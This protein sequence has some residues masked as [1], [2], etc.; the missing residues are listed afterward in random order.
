MDI[1]I[2]SPEQYYNLLFV[3]S[4]LLTSVLTSQLRSSC[5]DVRIFEDAGFRK[6]ASSPDSPA[7]FNLILLVDEPNAS[8]VALHM[9]I[10]NL[11]KSYHDTPVAV[12]SAH[13]DPERITRA[14]WAGAKGY[15]HTSLRYEA[16][17]H[18]LRVLMAGGE[19]VY[20]SP[21]P[22]RPNIARQVG[23]GLGGP[24]RRPQV[25]SPRERDVCDLLRQGL[26]NRS[27]RRRLC[28]LRIQSRFTFAIS[29][30]S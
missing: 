14:V 6:A 12:I 22:A 17:I 13:D 15:I 8:S 24:E 10:E 27:S 3:G 11:R 30:E 23:V 21:I 4:G 26:P 28:L 19:F 1:E 5:G 20:R 25:L 18:V 2:R 16:V 7:Q 29:C 9:Q